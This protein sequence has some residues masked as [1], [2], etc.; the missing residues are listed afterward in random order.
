MYSACHAECIND[1]FTVLNM[2]AFVFAVT[3]EDHQVWWKNVDTKFGNWRGH[4]SGDGVH[5]MMDYGKYIPEKLPFLERHI[6]LVS[7][8]VL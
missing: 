3:V 6:S 8:L 1:I 7:R 5:E 2:S 4:H